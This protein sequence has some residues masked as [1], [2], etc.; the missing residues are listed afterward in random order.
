MQLAMLQTMSSGA[1]SPT[2]MTSEGLMPQM[3]RRGSHIGTHSHTYIYKRISIGIPFVLGINDFI[4][5]H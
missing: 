5:I 2:I 3:W 1:L 4:C